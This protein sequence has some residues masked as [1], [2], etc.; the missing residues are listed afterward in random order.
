[1]NVLRTY[2][3]PCSLVGYL[4]AMLWSVAPQDSALILAP[5]QLLITP[6]PPPLLW[7]T[8]QWPELPELVPVA[9]SSGSVLASRSMHWQSENVSQLHHLISSLHPLL[10][11]VC[12]YLCY[13]QRLC[14]VISTL[15]VVFVHTSGIGWVL[16]VIQFAGLYIDAANALAISDKVLSFM[17]G[18]TVLRN[19]LILLK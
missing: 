3:L 4:L 18:L 15:S 1:M 9:H 5:L 6:P 11:R 12:L 16:D 14:V 19:L 13:L 17:C 10:W 8:T 7:L 2:R